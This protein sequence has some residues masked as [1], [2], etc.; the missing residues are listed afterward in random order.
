MILVGVLIEDGS[1]W[2][3]ETS[4]ADTPTV[5][6]AS[7]VA[8]LRQFWS[9]PHLALTM[10]DGRQVQVG[11]GGLPVLPPVLPE[12][13]VICLGLNYEDHIAEGSFKNASRNTYP[14][15]FG[16]W[17]RSLAVGG[18]TVRV[19][20]DERGLDWEGEV[21]AWVGSDLCEVSADEARAAVLG[22]STFND[23]TARAAQ[24]RTSQFALGKNVDRSG[25]VG[26]LVTAD[27]VGDLRDGLDLETRVNGDVVQK[28]STAN[29]IYELGDVLS[30]ASRTL[31]LRVGDIVCTGTPSG[32]GYA[33]E[34]EWLLDDGDVVEVS[35]ARLGTLRTRVVR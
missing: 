34:P 10:A 5:G 8:P 32:V 3:A 18:Q 14:T 25:P 30:Y 24:K 35:V 23:I 6:L 15:I 17:T 12:A 26:P 22:F 2:V 28:S 1:T 11:A 33:R 31:T 13:R 20:V 21:A 7:L 19:P 29:Q 27:V 16:R 4:N 9:D